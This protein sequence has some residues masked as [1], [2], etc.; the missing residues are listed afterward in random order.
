MVSLLLLFCGCLALPSAAA[1]AAAQSPPPLPNMFM[2]NVVEY[3]L[4]P[5]ENLTLTGTL[6]ADWDRNRVRFDY[7]SVGAVVSQF[8]DYSTVRPGGRGRGRDAEKPKGGT[9][10]LFVVCATSLSTGTCTSGRPLVHFPRFDSV[11]SGVDGGDW[12]RL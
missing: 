11:E 10:L 6:Y 8:Q 7:T 4:N 3:I 5:S 1:A 12:Q 2:S 9:C